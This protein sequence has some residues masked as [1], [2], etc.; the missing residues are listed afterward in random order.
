M[1]TVNSIPKDIHTPKDIDCVALSGLLLQQLQL[2][3]Q[4]VRQVNTKDGVDAK[5]GSEAS[6]PFEAIQRLSTADLAQ[7]LTTDQ[8]RK[9]FW[10]NLYNALYQMLRYQMLRRNRNTPRK[11]IF[12]M[13]AIELADVTLS[14]DDIEHTLLRGHRH[15]YSLGYLPGFPLAPAVLRPLMIRKPDYRIHFTL[16]CGARSCPPI[17]FYRAESIESQLDLATLSFI[18]QDT[19]IDTRRRVVRISR[20]YLWFLADF[21]GFRGIRRILGQTLG[22]SFDSLRIRFKTFDWTEELEKWS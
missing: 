8:A 11:G 22:Q 17:A 2:S 13:P 19:E 9:T 12:T 14:L 20:I 6:D 7:C 5:D 10:I 1:P 3:L 21:G 15:K 18:E 4:Q 16:N